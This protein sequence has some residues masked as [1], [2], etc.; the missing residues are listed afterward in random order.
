MIT[1][2][3]Q[4]G[5]QEWLDL[6]NKFFPASDAP[7]MM[8]VSPYKT[9]EDLLKERSTGIIPEV[10]AATQKRFDDGHRFEALARALAEEIIGE[11]L[12]PVV[13]SEG[14]YSASFDGLTMLEE[15]CFE[16]KTASG[17]LI[18]AIEAGNLPE[19]YRIQME[20]QLMVSGASKCLFMASKWTENDQLVIKRS[21]WYEPDMKLRERIIAGWEKFEEDLKNYTP[22][23]VKEAPKAEPIKALPSL[24]IQLRGEVAFSNLPA[25]KTAVE[26]FVEG[27]KT[28]LVTDED[29]VQADELAKFCEKAEKEL[30]AAKRSALAQTES[31][32]DLMRTVDHLTELMRQKRLTLEK[33]VKSEKETRKTAIISEAATAFCAYIESLEAETRPIQ[34]DVQRPD[35]AGAIKGKKTLASMQDAVDTVLR[36]AKIEADALAKDYRAK[37]AWC[38]ENAAGKSALFRD[39]Q[40]IISKPFDDFTLLIQSRIDK[41]KADEEA[42]LE[43]ERERIRQEE[44]AKLTEK[45]IE[46]PVPAQEDQKPNIPTGTVTPLH[47]EEVIDH[48]PAIRAFLDSR[49]FRD[50]DRIRA[51][52]VEYEKFRG[53]FGKVAA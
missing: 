20:Q 50:R 14:K 39:L 37:L 44:Q 35:F 24:S 32:D 47:T 33:L 1:H 46:Q 43:A 5:S 48:Q 53:A 34:L 9:R 51:I 21:C 15:I 25:F 19:H 30:Q 38:K 26:Q 27:I 22:R 8:G 42:R 23:E 45:P 49:D 7:A 12:F 13:G 31:I 52:L 18:D 29:F 17:A 6:R 3:V 2:D 4:Q 41:Q 36:N 28:E 11:E 16:H 40:Q 10:D